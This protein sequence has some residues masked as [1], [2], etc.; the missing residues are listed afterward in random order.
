MSTAG[1]DSVVPDVLEELAYVAAEQGQPERAARLLGASQTLRDARCLARWPVN[2]PRH[3]R[4]VQDVRERLG[5]DAFE[6]VR[7]AGGA[8]PLN[9]VVAFARTPLARV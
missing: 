3:E 7:R 4:I 1:P 9:E 2:Q 5:D 6:Q 8:M